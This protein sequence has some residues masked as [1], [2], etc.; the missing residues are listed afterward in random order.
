MKNLFDLTGKVALVTGASSGMGKEIAG[1]AVML[2]LKAGYVYYRSK[3][4]CRWQDDY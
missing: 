2:A 4:Y 1:V 3:Y